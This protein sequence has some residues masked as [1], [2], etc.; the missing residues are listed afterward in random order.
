MLIALRE[1]DEERAFS[2]ER[3]Y[4]DGTPSLFTDEVFAPKRVLTAQEQRVFRSRQAPATTPPARALVT[5]ARRVPP[6]SMPKCS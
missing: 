5:R 3:L 2:N 1:Q 4:V 6:M